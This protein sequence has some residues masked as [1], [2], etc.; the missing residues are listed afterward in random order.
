MVGNPS[1]PMLDK[2]GICT[3]FLNMETQ[4]IRPLSRSTNLWFHVC[5]TAI[6]KY[7]HQRHDWELQTR[8]QSLVPEKIF[9]W[10]FWIFK[11]LDRFQLD[12][13][14]GK[15]W[16]MDT[17]TIMDSSCGSKSKRALVHLSTCKAAANRS[18]VY[19]CWKNNKYSLFLRQCKVYQPAQSQRKKGAKKNTCYVGNNTYTI[20][21]LYWLILSFWLI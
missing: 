20:Y 12:C 8:V 4:G 10:D 19:V 11:Y 7:M 16:W 9:S 6:Q 1:G 17:Y 21:T 2:F 3:S 18:N 14:N 13:F 15:K 5:I